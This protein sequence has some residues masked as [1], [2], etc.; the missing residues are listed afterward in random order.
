MD[1]AVA[2][3]DDVGAVAGGL[4]TEFGRGGAAAGEELEVD[5]GALR[6][7]VFVVEVVE[8][9]AEALVEDGGAAESE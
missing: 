9:A 1:L 7:P 5:G 8:F 2:D 3:L 4:A 6:G